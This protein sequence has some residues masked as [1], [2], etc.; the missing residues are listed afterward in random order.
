M[1]IKMNDMLACQPMTRDPKVI[2]F[3]VRLS[4]PEEQEQKTRLMDPDWHECWICAE[5]R[6]RWGYGFI[7]PFGCL[8]PGKD[9]T[10]VPDLCKRHRQQVFGKEYTRRGEGV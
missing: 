8:D 4:T 2:D 5:E 3:D 6:K 1:M 9:P 10:P 7:S